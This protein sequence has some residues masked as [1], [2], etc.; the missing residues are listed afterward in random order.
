MKT[1]GTLT[2]SGFFWIIPWQ[3][4]GSIIASPQWI[5]HISDNTSYP[6]FLGMHHHKTMTGKCGDQALREMA[7]AA[8]SLALGSGS[9]LG[10]GTSH[11]KPEKHHGDSFCLGYSSSVLWA[12]WSPENQ[13]NMRAPP[14]ICSS[15]ALHLK[16]ST[17]FHPLPLQVG[18]QSNLQI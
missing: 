1:Q 14:G 2:C 7:D 10:H 4:L 18:A 8:G 15:H 13:A 16:H 9:A 12:A 3:I 5:C 17:K 11:Q 6:S